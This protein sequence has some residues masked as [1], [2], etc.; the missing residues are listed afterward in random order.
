[1][2]LLEIGDGVLGSVA[3]LLTVVVIFIFVLAL[4]Y[5]TT[6]LAGGIKKQQMAGKNIQIMETVTISGSKFLQIVKVGS[7][8]FLIGISKDSLEYMTELSEE[9]LCFTENS[10]TPGDSFQFILEKLKKD[11][12]DEKQDE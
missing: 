9:D 10:T 4:T 8:Y 11:K 12:Q 7:R 6:R 3:Q 5:G 2:I 1:M